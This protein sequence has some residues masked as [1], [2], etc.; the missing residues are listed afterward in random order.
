MARQGREWS[1]IDI[2]TMRIFGKLRSE[3]GYSYRR[4][5]ELTGMNHTRVLDLEKMKNG[6]PTLVEF[7]SLC[8]AFGLDAPKTLQQVIES[9]KEN[10]KES[11]KTQYA[12]DESDAEDMIKSFSKGDNKTL[13]LA[14]DIEKDKW[15]EARGGDGR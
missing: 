5:G 12:K 15:L 11:T 10:D 14:A 9:A 7:L 4:L 1:G 8:W 6:T 2:A 3:N 13:G